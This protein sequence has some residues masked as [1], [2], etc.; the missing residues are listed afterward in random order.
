L[1][2]ETELKRSDISC[3]L[4]QPV[5]RQ[6]LCYVTRVNIANHSKYWIVYW[7]F[8]ATSSKKAQGLCF[9]STGEK[10][11]YWLIWRGHMQGMET[12]LGIVV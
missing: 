3:I 4:D 6:K 1:H 8:T 10:P 5:R 12:K 2:K 9:R 11:Y 7:M